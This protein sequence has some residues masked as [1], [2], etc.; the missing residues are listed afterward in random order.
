MRTALRIWLGLGSSLLL[1]ACP[2]T[3]SQPAAAGLTGSALVSGESCDPANAAGIA[4]RLERALLDTIAFAEGTRGYG[5]DGYNVTFGYRYFESCAVHPNIKVCSGS[6]CSTAAGRYQML[7]KTFQ[8]LKLA[9]FW[10]Q[11]QEL[12]ALE[13]IER[14]G[15]T[16]P[17]TAMTATQFANALDKL[18]YEWSSLPPGRYG[19]TR[20]TLDQIRSEYCRLANCA[21]STPVTSSAS[22][23]SGG[24]PSFLT[25]EQDGNLYR[26]A[27]D[28]A[29]NFLGTA[30]SSGWETVT[31]MGARA[32]YDE[33]GADDFLAVDFE[34]GLE[35]YRGDAAGSFQLV[36][37]AVESSALVL[38]GAG[39]DYDGDGHADFIA[40]DDAEQLLLMR[41]DGRARF[42]ARVLSTLADDVRAIGGG[43][44]YTG[45]GRAD[46]ATLREDGLALLYPGEGGGYFG[47]ELLDLDGPALALLGRA[48][49]F[50]GDGRLDLLAFAVD[51]SAYV[52]ASLGNGQF[53]ARS[54]GVGWD[55]IVFVD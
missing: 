47:V 46:F 30:I 52:Y 36:P 6:L 10:P 33:D 19:Q 13:L 20:R 32:D 27:P 48:A 54:L 39:A 55:A 35:L 24:A 31:S 1:M 43:G 3:D 14:R 53:Q 2:P 5:K 42:T 22:A 26:Y 12:G 23:A 4:G 8:G 18:S 49:D 28:G 41:G 17:A 44:D 29:G 37:L 45:D 50:T 11:D 7:H 40:V 34:Y 16:L 9:S 15:V 25:V 51:G 38:L 21:A